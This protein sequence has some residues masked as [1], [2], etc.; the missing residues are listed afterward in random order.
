MGGVPLGSAQ[1]VARVPGRLDR[2]GRGPVAGG[3]GRLW[4]ASWRPLVT[5]DALRW[6]L[7]GS[8]LGGLALVART[9]TGAT[10]WS[11]G[12]PLWAMLLGAGAG[13]FGRRMGRFHVVRR[14]ARSEVFLKVG[15]VLLGA[16]VPL[17][18]VR[19]VGGRGL[20]LVAL[21]VVTVFAFTWW[22]ATKLALDRR[23]RSVLCS[24]VAVSGLSGAA[25]TAAAVRAQSEQLGL[26]TALVILTGLPMSVLQP[27]MARWLH[28]PSPVAG[29][30]VGSN[31]DTTATV[32]AA[33]S[34]LG[35]GPLRVASVVKVAQNCLIGLVAAALAAAGD[36]RRGLCVIVDAWRRFPRFLLGFFG[37][38]VVASAGW[39]SP[40]ALHSVAHLR[41][42]FLALGFVCLGFTGV[43]V[44]LPRGSRRAAAVF[45]L[46]TAFS[47]AV[48]LGYSWL[49]FSR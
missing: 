5:A 1:E 14:L 25:A 36:G 12:Y 7:A 26:V 2:G 15:L 19:S 46:A 4:L 48:S 31:L 11:D 40:Q 35:E 41:N 42:W 30:W 43:G 32:L 47:T 28:L 10:G 39:L 29:A 38:S 24:A 13:A 3:D 21:G 8:L 45:L 27:L 6:A 9:L 49:L 34:M 16:S 17:G 37:A 20:A 44:A 33:G 18:Q 22:L 23:L